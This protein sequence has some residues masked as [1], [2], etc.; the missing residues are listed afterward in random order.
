MKV[1]TI[2]V[3]SVLLV[4]TLAVAGVTA[5]SDAIDGGRLNLLD[6]PCAFFND[7][8]GAAE[9][10]VTANK[11]VLKGCWKYDPDN[12]VVLLVINGVPFSMPAILFQ[13]P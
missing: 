9:F 7:A 6:E 5:F 10:Q 1:K 11:E 12:N 8:D 3:A 2:L 13:T 4:A